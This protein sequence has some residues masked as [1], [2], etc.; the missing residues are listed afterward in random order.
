MNQQLKKGLTLLIGLVIS[1][2]VLYYLIGQDIETLRDELKDAR[3]EYVFLS[4]PIFVLALVT[5]GFRWRAL[6][7]YRTSTWHAFHIMNV[8]YL[9]SGIVPRL[10]E[11]ARAWLTTRLDPPVKFFT[12]LSSIIVERV[13]DLLSVIVL[14]GISLLV[15]DVPSEVSS[16]GALLGLIAFVMSAVMLY[17]ALNRDQAHQILGWSM[18][19][20]PFLQRFKLVDWLDHILDGLSPLL[21]WRTALDVL[22]WNAISWF[23]SIVVGYLLMMVFFPE[24]DWAG[25][26]LMIVLL[27]L[28]VAIPSVPGNLGPF[29]AA[30]V[31]GLWIADIIPST[32]APDNAPAV[33]F[34]LLLHAINLGSYAVMGMIGLWFEHTSLGQVRQAAQHEIEESEERA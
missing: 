3:Y 15:L 9:L 6:L 29:E 25:I 21:H 12:S 28:A 13:L 4:M 34:G 17:F 33:A 16:A 32:D 18:A 2:G 10:G 30:V 19:R 26:T 5:R 8:G 20:L 23:L 31:A 1:G 22:F 27:A 24:G 14:L 7:G 11:P